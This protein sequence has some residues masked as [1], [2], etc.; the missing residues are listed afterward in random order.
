MFFEQLFRWQSDTLCNNAFPQ[1][2]SE[3]KRTLEECRRAKYGKAPTT[4]EEIQSDFRKFEIFEDLGR[5]RHRERGIFF[6][7][8]HIEAN[9]CNCI[10]SSAKSISLII[11]NIREKDRFFIMDGTF[12]I[13]PRGVFQQVLIIY[14]YYRNKVSA[15]HFSVFQI[16]QYFNINTYIEV[17]LKN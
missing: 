16:F 12:R 6:N 17:R 1:T 10:F 2:F 3:V 4:G 13:T 11:E 14:L 15:I 8:I 5:S 9:Y 7:D